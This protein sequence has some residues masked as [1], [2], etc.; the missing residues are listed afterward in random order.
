[1]KPT[2]AVA[3]LTINRPSER[4]LLGRVGD[5]ELFEQ[6]AARIQAD[7]AIRCAILTGAGIGVLLGRRRQG[8]ARAQRAIFRQL[9]EAARQLPVAKSTAW[10]GRCGT[11][12]CR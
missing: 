6:A 10:C 9:R 8:H 3:L 5:G 2:G 12:T 7:N 11:S 4:N 1:M